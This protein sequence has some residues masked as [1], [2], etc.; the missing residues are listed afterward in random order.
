MVGIPGSAGLVLIAGVAHLNEESA[1]FEAMLTGWGRQQ[2][3][4]LLGEKTIGDRV[5]VVRRFTEFAES[6]P[7]A[8][9]PG[10]VEDFTVSLA[11]RPSRRSST[12][13]SQPATRS[14]RTATATRT[15]SR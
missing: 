11:S 8:W 6:Y 15:R 13:S 7:W 1:V 5:R 12:R 3:S 10:D 4:R 14:G 9:G 2:A